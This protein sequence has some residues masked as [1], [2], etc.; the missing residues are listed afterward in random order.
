LGVEVRETR[1]M[2]LEVLG[3]G[4]P[5]VAVVGGIHGDEPCGRD[6]VERFLDDPPAVDRP[7]A[8]VVAN[9]EA[10]AANS[11]FVDEDLNRAFPGDRDA[12]THEGRLA[13]RLG[14]A[15]SD[16]TTLSLHST[17][18]FGEPFG[19]VSGVDDFAREIAPR[20]PL[21]A[22]VDTGDFDRGRIFEAVPRT[23][24]IECGFQGTAE[25]AANG[26][27]VTRAFLVATGVLP[28]TAAAAG[29]S[30]EDRRIDVFR[31]EDS[32]P[33]RAAD[34]Y[35]VSVTNFDLVAAGEPFAATDGEQVLAEEDFYPV[36]MSA[37]GYEELFGYTA[38]FAGTLP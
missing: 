7:V 31:L 23:I 21:V 19:I 37:D 8:F 6:A 2:R 33:K 25:A 1:Y 24:E 28:P 14:E 36:L 5:E 17:R 16:C 22:L 29:E 32:V 35:E 26:I 13:A 11:R 9:E 30:D 18:S 38:S 20:L 27:E 3:D 10:L 12:A 34:R 4:D 15:L